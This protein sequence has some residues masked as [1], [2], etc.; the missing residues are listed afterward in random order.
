MITTA[1]VKPKALSGEI[2]AIPS[3][4]HVHRLLIASS[5][6][7]KHCFIPCGVLSGD[8]SATCACLSALGAGIEIRDGGIYVTPLTRDEF[9]RPFGTNSPVLEC[10]ESG[11]TYRFIAPVICATGKGGAFLLKGRLAHRPM[12]ELWR[13]LESHGCSVSG[14]GKDRVELSGVLTPGDYKIRGDISSQFL[15]GLLFALPLLGGGSNIVVEGEIMSKGYVER[16]LKTLRFFCVDVSFDKD[17][18]TFSVKGEQSYSLPFSGGGE[19]PVL[20]PV[21]DYSNSAF[22]LCAA[23][24]GGGDIAMSG[25]PTDSS[26]VDSEVLEILRR[27]GAGVS[28][29]DGKITVTKQKLK[30]ITIDAGDIPDLVMP[31]AA[32]AAAAEGISVFKNVSRLK[33]KES[34]RLDAVR[35]TINSLGGKASHNGNELV[36]RGTGRIKGGRADSHGDHRIVMMAAILSVIAEGDIVITGADDVGKSYP[37]FFS[38]F[39]KLGGSV[40]LN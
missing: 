36:I 16:T 32:V 11:S 27:F 22:W 19:T 35:D 10:G 26:Q 14:K 9:G 29:A 18:N 24:A 31:L 38:D 4:S 3:K 21:G 1:T 6:A 15:S 39:E 30:G 28:R 7:D 17:N 25:L 37:N 13:A 23:A 5:L 34:D 2:C 12:D 20:S 40:T 33:L 8:I